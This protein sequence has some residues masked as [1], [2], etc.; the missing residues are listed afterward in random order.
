MV[1]VCSL[2]FVVG[3]VHALT[4]LEMGL[5]DAVLAGDEAR[6]ERMLT[7]GADVNATNNFGTTALMLAAMKGNTRLVKLL[8]EKGADVRATERDGNTALRWA[9]E[10]G[11]EKIFRM[12]LER[13]AAIAEAERTVEVT[14]IPPLYS[15]PKLA[16]EGIWQGTGMPAGDK[17][18]PLIYRTLYRPSAKFP[19]SIVYMLLF[20]LK[21][22]S[23][24]LYAGSNEPGASECDS[25]VE[26][27]EQP[28]L[29]AITNA[30]WQSRHTIRGGL[31]CR[32][33]VLKK[34]VNGIATLILFKDGSVDIRE[35]N[36]RIPVS[37][38]RD[39]RQLKHLIVKDGKVV[40]SIRRGGKDVDAEIGL[41]FLLNEDNPILRPQSKNPQEKKR[42]LNINRGPLWFIA[43]RSAFGIREDGNLVYALGHHI[44]TRDLAKALALAGCVRAIHGD[45]NPG[46]C[47]GI[48]YYANEDGTVVS[49]T[50]LYPQQSRSTLTRYVDRSYPKDFVAYFRRSDRCQYLPKNVDWPGL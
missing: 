21:R 35:W 26:R 45:A 25:K 5:W 38:V 46:S 8:L 13:L 16:G 27:F 12:L 44:S 49:K 43:M 30:L 33:K 32:G 18:P 3:R 36:D 39:A 15:E 20:N 23:V 37:L 41:G 14:D 28:F 1:V 4:A 11:H 40:T 34:M 6:A 47:V 19:N 50:R 48:L 24:R 42:I 31:I 29:L 17:D 7:E 22:V 9:L 10:K 2:L